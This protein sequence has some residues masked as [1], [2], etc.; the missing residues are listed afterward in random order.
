MLEYL[1]IR[2]VIT[3]YKWQMDKGYPLGLFVDG[4]NKEMD[5]VINS[6]K[7]HPSGAREIGQ[8]EY[9]CVPG[10]EKG[11][12]C[13]LIGDATVQ[14]WTFASKITGGNINEKAG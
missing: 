14:V 3:I 13:N 7:A 12:I 11:V 1:R 5:N 4:A 8:R 6:A 2:S 10:V 9:F